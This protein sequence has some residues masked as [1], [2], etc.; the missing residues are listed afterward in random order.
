MLDFKFVG[1]DILSQNSSLLELYDGKTD[2]KID[3]SNET[4]DISLNLICKISFNV[5]KLVSNQGWKMKRY[6][7]GTVELIKQ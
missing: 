5:N 1:G 3:R 2:G 4:N 7:D 6:T